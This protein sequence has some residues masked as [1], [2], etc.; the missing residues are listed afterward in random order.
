[1]SRVVVKQHRSTH[2]YYFHLN[3]GGY[4]LD[5]LAALPACHRQCLRG[6]RVRDLMLR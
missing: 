6:A 1:M 2:L 5:A 3:G 4:T